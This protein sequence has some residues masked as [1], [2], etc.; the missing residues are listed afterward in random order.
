MH[1]IFSVWSKKELGYSIIEIGYYLIDHKV[2][3]ACLFFG[4]FLYHQAYDEYIGRKKIFSFGKEKH[5]KALQ[6]GKQFLLAFV[7]LFF[8]IGLSI[9]GYSH[10]S[11][12]GK[13]VVLFQVLNYAFVNYFF[14][15]LFYALLA[16]CIFEINNWIIRVVEIVV[17]YLLFTGILTEYIDE[18][19]LISAFKTKILILR[20]VS[21]FRLSDSTHKG[22]TINRFLGFSVQTHQI[23][24]IIVWILICA[25][26]LF[27]IYRKKRVKLFLGAVIL[28]III[29]P[30]ED[31]SPN[32]YG[33]FGC[34]YPMYYYEENPIYEEKEA[35]FEVS[36]YQM[37]FVF[38]QELSAKVTMELSKHD[39]KEYCFTLY[40]PYK[41]TKVTN[42]FGEKLEYNQQSDY[43]TVIA[44]D[45]SKT[46]KITIW[47]HGN[48][49]EFY[50]QDIGANLVAGICFY[51]KPGFYK[52]YQEEM[53]QVK[54]I[55]SKN[56]STYKVHI[57]SPQKVYSNLENNNENVFGGTSDAVGFYAGIL[58][59]TTINDI[60]FVDSYINEFEYSDLTGYNE[61]VSYIDAYSENNDAVNLHNRTIFTVNYPTSITPF[62][63]ARENYAIH[64]GNY[65]TVNLQELMVEN[66]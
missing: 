17:S 38:W 5:Y 23:M 55:F 35:N 54:L 3:F 9:W 33:S 22:Y 26:F 21:F 57:C 60:T 7:F 50:S 53:G 63:F 64:R 20:I 30:Y 2:L 49:K 42:Q 56:T 41:I 12:S 58:H 40:H 39:L 43:V 15:Y 25:T 37:N 29:L 59:E 4:M 46:E 28:I 10:T 16:G 6:E 14:V 48:G 19:I 24:L 52:L 36:E 1:Y 62:S 8:I 27:R 18:Q 45:N 66:E 11:I 61:A 51:P 65:S 32:Y 13:N 44:K 31:L 47:Y 34:F